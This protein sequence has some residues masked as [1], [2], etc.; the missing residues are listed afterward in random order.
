MTKKGELAFLMSRTLRPTL[1]ATLVGPISQIATVPG[2]PA[3]GQ[4]P[5]VRQRHAVPGAAQG[6]AAGGRGRV[7]YQHVHGVQVADGRMVARA[8]HAGRAPVWRVAGTRACRTATA[9][10]YRSA[11]LLHS[12]LFHEGKQQCCLLLR[13]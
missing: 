1:I 12:A 8:V 11:R 4:R 10:A 2:D 13:Y 7:L 3:R 6:P 9:A 5:F